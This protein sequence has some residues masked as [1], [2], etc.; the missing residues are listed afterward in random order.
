[1]HISISGV[2]SVKQNIN[3][4]KMKD[5]INLNEIIDSSLTN[6]DSNI[7]QFSLDY[8]LNDIVLPIITSWITVFV[9]FAARNYLKK[10]RVGKYQKTKN[11]MN[12]ENGFYTSV[13]ENRSLDNDFFRVEIIDLEKPFII[14]FPKNKK[15]ELEKYEFTSIYNEN[16]NEAIREDLNCYIQTHYGKIIQNENEVL[17]FIDKISEKTADNFINQIKDRKVR[18]NKFLF[19]VY[20]VKR[21]NDKCTI[22]VYQSDYFTFKC[23]TNVFNTL[24]TFT[25]HKALPSLKGE[26]D[27]AKIRPFLNSIGIGGFLIMDR[28]KGDEIVLALRGNNCD[29]GGYWHFSFDETFT[30]DDKKDNYSLKECLKRGLVEELGI[31]SEEQNKALPENQIILLDSGI[32]HTDNNDN[33]FE[34]EVCA[35]ARI[36][37]SKQY[38]FDDF[39]KGYRFA[40]DAE[41]ETRCLDF[42]PINQIDDF[43]NT[44]RMSPE[45][46]A[47]LNN[48]KYLHQYNVLETDEEGFDSLQH[49]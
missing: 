36:C 21:E 49:K 37:F 13:V 34:F 6:I 10:Y 41:L 24:K 4:Y 22:T 30:S 8:F 27:I 18:F 11:K 31:L 48:I 35:I 15:E 47:L 26:I 44:H 39:I 40:K 16:K 38:T 45:A 43:I 19:G 32:I 5:S 20:D 42:I 2:L 28:G 17:N 46:K 9:F 29:S 3:I 12:Q 23:M 7:Y 14:P 25:P 1:M 33:R